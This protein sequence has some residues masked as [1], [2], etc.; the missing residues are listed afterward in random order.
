MKNLLAVIGSPRKLGNCEIAAKMISRQITEPHTLHLLR[1]ADFDIRL[2]T[3]CYACLLKDECILGDDLPQV[4]EAFARADAFIIAAPTYCLGAN[5]S[6]KVLADRILAFYSR[7]T[8]IWGKP[9][10]GVGVAGIEGKEG[11]SKLN[12]D[13]FMRLFQMHIKASDILYGAMPG[14][15]ALNEAN[16]P[17]I[18][19][20]AAALFSDPLVDEAPR[21]PLFDGDTFRFYPN[22]RIRCMLCSNEGRMDHKNGRPLFHVEPSTHELLLSQEDALNHGK[23]LK[24]MKEKFKGDKTRLKEIAIEFAE[25]GSWIRPGRPPGDPAAIR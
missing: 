7:S 14:E 6:L 1:L 4:L 5:A 16:K 9:A 23:W 13:A 17:W 11:S 25:L 10:I 3:G 19:R 8:Q 24:H 20:A 2:C 21:C 12:I 22:N 15:V 18:K